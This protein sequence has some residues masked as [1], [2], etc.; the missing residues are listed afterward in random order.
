MTDLY[1]VKRRHI[2]DD[3]IIPM[4]NIVF[5]LLIF[6]MIAG[7]IKNPLN[8]DIELPRTPLGSSTEPTPITL[9][10]DRQHHLFLNREPVEQ[11][12]LNEKLGG[13]LMGNDVVSLIVDRQVRAAELDKVLA[14]FRK[15]GVANLTLYSQSGE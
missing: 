6:F 13:L 11:Q 14:V 5:L 4:I 3:N 9:E 2:G 7:Q 1:V 15:L 8:D 10:L 12:Q